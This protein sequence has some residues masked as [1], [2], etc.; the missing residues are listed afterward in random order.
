MIEIFSNMQRAICDEIRG[1]QDYWNIV[2]II[3]NLCILVLIGP[4]WLNPEGSGVEPQ[5]SQ[6]IEPW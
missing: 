4:S 2:G 5:P 3:H 6:Q 1:G